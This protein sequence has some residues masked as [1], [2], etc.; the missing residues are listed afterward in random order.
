MSY[1]IYEGDMQEIIMESEGME[2]HAYG[3]RYIAWVSYSVKVVGE[4]IWL[5][6][7]NTGHILPIEIKK[8]HRLQKVGQCQ[9]HYDLSQE[10]SRYRRGEKVNPKQVKTVIE[11]RNRNL[12]EKEGRMV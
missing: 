7:L 10:V 9:F 4:N 11:N 3:E 5:G 6:V 2:K 1:T 8:K 12:W